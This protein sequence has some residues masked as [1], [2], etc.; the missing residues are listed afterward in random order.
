MKLHDV[1]WI[2]VQNGSVKFVLIVDSKKQRSALAWIPGAVTALAAE[3]LC[4][5]RETQ[6]VPC[7][8]RMQLTQIESGAFSFSLL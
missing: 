3:S 5:N 1:R 6:T 7:E 8:S 2:V 4:E